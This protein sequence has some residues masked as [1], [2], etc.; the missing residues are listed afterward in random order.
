MTDEKFDKRLE[1]WVEMETKAA[2]EMRPSTEMYRLVE[3]KGGR[4]RTAKIQQRRVVAVG[5]AFTALI[6]LIIGGIILGYPTSWF[7][8]ETLQIVAIVEQRQGSN[9]YPELPE[10][11]KGRIDPSFQLLIFQVFRG[12]DGTTESLD[13]SEPSTEWVRLTTKDDFRLLIQPFQSRYLYIYLINPNGDYQAL[14]LEDGFNP[15]H[16]VVRTLLP[17]QPDWFYL[18]GK[19]KTY[20]LVLVTDTNAIPEL[21]VLDDQY[22][23]L[24]S[25]PEAEPIRSNLSESLESIIRSGS[26]DL[27]VREVTLI[28]ED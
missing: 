1:N 16:P 24:A 18:S 3:S 14:H 9:I 26:G 19:N 25:D 4:V 23:Q 17:S 22:L 6:I 7:R 21:E 11:G 20:Q 12:D 28:L 15:L 13:L 5:F 8:S 2:P 10:K 27:E